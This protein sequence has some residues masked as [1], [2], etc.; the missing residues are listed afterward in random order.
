[1]D[2]AKDVLQKLLKA[3]VHIGILKQ[4]L[5]IVNRLGLLLG[6]C[7]PHDR[8][9]IHQYRMSSSLYHVLSYQQGIWL[10]RLFSDV[11]KEVDHVILLD[12]KTGIF[13]Y[14]A[15][16]HAI[17]ATAESIRACAGPNVCNLQIAVVLEL[18]KR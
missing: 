3:D 2:E 14:P 13:L 6:L 10:L 9:F 15:E 5:P 12:T 16:K 4:S 1:M 11:G 18:Y 8:P 7:N 17:K